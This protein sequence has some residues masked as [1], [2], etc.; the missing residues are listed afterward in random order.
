[1][2]QSGFTISY[3]MVAN[4]PPNLGVYNKKAYFLTLAAALFPHHLH[5]RPRAAGADPIWAMLGCGTGKDQWRI[6]VTVLKAATRI[7]S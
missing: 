6:Q 3:T 7:C 5:S 2:Y 4:N 1:M